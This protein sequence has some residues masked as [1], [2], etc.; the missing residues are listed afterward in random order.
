M[1]H[2]IK[3]EEYELVRKLH[4]NSFLENILDYK[5]YSKKYNLETFVYY[6]KNILKGYITFNK[7]A[8]DNVDI[9]NILVDEK[10]QKNNI[11]SKLL[12]RLIKYC[13][14]RRITFISCEVRESNIKAINFYYKNKFIFVRKI[15]N[16]YE[17][18]N[19]LF[20]QRRVS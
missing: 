10:Y 16:Y 20:L 18:E 5:I 19:A 15:N 1:I 7:L 2:L 3:K 14:K 17:N 4:N 13:L 11:A 8:Y 12:D 6:E 9:Y